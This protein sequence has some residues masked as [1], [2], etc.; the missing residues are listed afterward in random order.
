MNEEEKKLQP[1]TNVVPYSALNSS[2]WLP[3]TIRAITFFTSKDFR[4]LSPTIPP[5]SEGGYKGSSGF[6]TSIFDAI[7]KNI[8]SG[9]DQSKEI[10]RVNNKIDKLND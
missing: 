4:R 2:N 1:V 10:V 3:S 8:D 6:F 9:R 5:N 7:L